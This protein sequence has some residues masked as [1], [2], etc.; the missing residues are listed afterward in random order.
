[1]KIKLLIISL[2]YPPDNIIAA[3]RSEAYARHFHK[4]GVYPTIV[5][6]IVEK[7][8]DE[9]GTWVAYKNHSKEVQPVYEKYKTH[10]VIRLP[11]FVPLLQKMQLFAQRFKLFSPIFTFVLNLLGHFDMHLLGH[12]Q[13]YREFLF[14]HLQKT[15]YDAILAIDSPH[16]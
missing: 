5:T 9:N 7:V 12:T 15:N 8:Y 4:F 6:D 16:F 3:R 11:R 13:N 10:A 1:M 14:K 2:H